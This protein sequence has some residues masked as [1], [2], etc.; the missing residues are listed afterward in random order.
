MSVSVGIVQLTLPKAIMQVPTSVATMQV[1]RFY[2]N[3]VGDTFCCTYGGGFFCC[4]YE[5]DC[6]CCNYAV[7]GR[8]VTR[9][10]RRGEVSPALFQNLK[11]SDLIWE[12]NAQ[13]RFSF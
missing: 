1:L 7:R 13:T 3:Y 2:C 12:K 11:K 4:S 9:G 10:V 8:R 6:F 5:G